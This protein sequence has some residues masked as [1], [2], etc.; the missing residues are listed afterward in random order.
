MLVLYLFSLAHRSVPYMVPVVAAV[1]KV[2]PSKQGQARRKK[3]KW[4][5]KVEAPWYKT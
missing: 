4:N 2:G 3:G 5:N 1:A